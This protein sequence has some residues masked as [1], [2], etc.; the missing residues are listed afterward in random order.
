MQPP[1]EHYALTYKRRPVVFLTECGSVYPYELP[2]VWYVAVC[3]DT[4][5]GTLNPHFSRRP[6]RWLELSRE[7]HRTNM[8]HQ[9]RVRGWL[10]NSYGIDREAMGAVRIT[11]REG[12]AVFRKVAA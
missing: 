12:R 3:A 5:S 6:G 4:E 9:P 8:S 2:G 1:I 10:G 11:M 7:P